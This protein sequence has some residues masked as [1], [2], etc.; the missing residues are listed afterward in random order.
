M[1]LEWFT[2]LGLGVIFHHGLSGRP[3]GLQCDITANGNDHLGMV[4]NVGEAGGVRKKFAASKLFHFTVADEWKNALIQ[5]Y[6]AVRGSI[7]EFQ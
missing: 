5:G 7:M 2:K 3:G 4:N 6:R 1:I